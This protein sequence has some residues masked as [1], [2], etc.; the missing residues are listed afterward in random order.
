MADMIPEDDEKELDPKELK[1]AEKARKKEEK[2]LKKKE[3]KEAK[4]AA[5]GEAEEQ[6]ESVGGKIVIVFVTILIVAI[7]LG[8]FALLI[9]WDVG[10]FGSSVLYPVL[11]DVPYVN[12]ILPEVKDEAK[13]DDP[14]GYASVD[15]A[16]E[17]I[18]K[19]EKQLEK[20][21][22]SSGNSNETISDLKDEVA[23]LQVFEKQQADFEKQK[24]K[25]YEEVVFGDSAPDIKEYKAY[26]ESIDPENAEQLYKQVISQIQKDEDVADYVKAYSDMKPAAAA[27]IMENM[28]DN[29]PLCAKI[30]KNMKA[31]ARGDIL[32]AMNAEVAAKLTKL[33]EP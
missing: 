8:I 32:A 12:K 30:L 20:A 1:K 24:S 6:P 29:L 27:G 26:Y 3:K 7:W 28:T 16:V 22:K 15:E 2:A 21:K 5:E 17:Q 11:K 14:Y 9:K 25:F 4:E 23:R 19:L 31:G 13:E 33:M 10:G 18:K